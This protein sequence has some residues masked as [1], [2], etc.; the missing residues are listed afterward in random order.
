MA[1]FR[2][3][4]SPAW[5][6]ILAWLAVLWNLF[7]VAMYLSSVGVLGDQTAG[8]SDAERAAAESIPPLV[9]GA[10]AIGTFAGLLGSIG[11]VMRRRWAVPVLLVSMIAL[12]I[13]EGWIVFLSNAVDVFGLAVPI[14]V[15]LIA[16]LLA[17]AAFQARRRGWLR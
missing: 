1:A 15:S 9:T 10:F 8:M 13:L 11:L 16:I 6:R 12:L 3:Q 4:T 2:P 14:T 7:G 5:F 17:W